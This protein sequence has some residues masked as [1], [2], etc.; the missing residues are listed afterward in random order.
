MT[1]GRQPPSHDPG[2]SA[3]LRTP[4]AVL[5]IRTRDD[6]LIGVE[7]LPLSA[8]SSAPVD[9]FAA[10]V[11]R[12]LRCYLADPAFRFALPLA[13]QG[14]PFQR[15]VWHAIDGIPPG[16]TRSYGELAQVLH[17]GP[18]AVGN[19]CGDNPI[20]VVTPCHR[21]VGAHGSLGGFGG[22][23]SDTALAIKR[24]LLAHEGHRVSA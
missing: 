10:E 8:R 9:A 12:Q 13:P 6:L 14:T 3:K 4:F 24:W 22:G 15:R 18:R 17:T 23:G 1:R 20:A 7:F 16:Q 11:V 19:A 21:V 5:G 2:F